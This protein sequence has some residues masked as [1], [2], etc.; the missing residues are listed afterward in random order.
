[1]TRNAYKFDETGK[2]NT[3]KKAELGSCIKSLHCVWICQ[4]LI[5]ISR[6]NTNHQ[7]V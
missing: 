5:W 6:T 7:S 1:M 2:M 3:S 4:K